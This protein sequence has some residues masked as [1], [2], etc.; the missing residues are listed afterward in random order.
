M[1][2]ELATMSVNEQIMATRAMALDPLEFLIKNRVLACLIALPLL[3]AMA[4]FLGIAGGYVIC[5]H[6]IDIPPAAY[7]NQVRESLFLKDFV[8]G[9]GKSVVFALLIS[10]I[11]CCKGLRAAGG[12]AGVGRATTEAVALASI[13]IVL[14]DFVMTK[15]V[16][17]FIDRM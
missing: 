5:V 2:A 14:S 11:C 1:A 13:A 8:S 17:T 7:V 16:V 10:G 3:V 4:D 12:S 15:F 6:D 9:I